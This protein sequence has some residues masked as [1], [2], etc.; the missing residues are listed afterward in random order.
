[1]RRMSLLLILLMAGT[2]LA[3]WLVARPA[4]A[5]NHPTLEHE[6]VV[7]RA[8]FDDP[9][10]VAVVARTQEPWEVDYHKNFMVLEVD[11]AEYQELERLG[12]RLEV[13]AEL[14]AEINKIRLPLPDQVSGIPG[15]PCY[16][17]V[18]E[19]FATAVAL[20]ANYPTLAEWI[21]VGDS[22]EK[23]AG[24]GGY[25]M[26]VLILTNEAIQA[27][28]PKL[29]VTSAIHAREYTTAELMTRFAE[30]LIYAY[31][32]DADA[33]WLLDHHEV[34]LMLHTNPDG[35]KQAETGLSWRKNTNQNYCGP[36]SSSRGADLNRNFQFQWGCCGGSSGNECSETF[37][38][39]SPAS[40][41]EVQAVQNY[42]FANYPDLRDP[43]LNAAAPVTTTGIYLDIHSYSE[44]VLWSWGFTATPTANGTALQTL[45]RKMA[46]F[47]GYFPEQAIGLYPTDGTTDDF[48]YGELGLPS[49]TFELGTA[50]FQGCGFFEND[51][52]PGNMPALIYA[53]KAA[54]EPYLAPAGPEP[55]D[56]EVSEIIV[57]SGTPVTLTAV[58][59]DTR[60]NNQNGTEPTQNI[61]AGEYYLD[62]PP[63]I[64]E[65]TPVALPLT[66]VDG[67]FN[68]P[69]E[70]AY[71]V[72]DTSVLADGRH[73]IYVRGQDATGQ[74]G[75]V[76]AA[77]LFIVDP[78]IA[79]V[80][81]GEVSAA[82]TGLPLAATITANTIFQTQ[83]DPLTGIYQMQVI[84]DTYAITAVPD[85]PNYASATVSG[86][87][88]QNSQTVVQD[89]QLYP[90]CDVFFDDV[91]AGNIGWTFDPPWAI[92]TEASHSPTHSWTDSPGGNY[93]NNRNIAITSPIIDLTDYTNIRLNYWQI[94]D[95][96]ADYDFCHVEVS[97]DGGTNW[98]EIGSFDGPHTQWEEITLDASLL[99][100]QAN[101]RI[102]FRFTSD[103]S[104]VDD[105]WHVDDIRLRG[106]GPACVDYVAPNASFTTS[107]P[108]ALGEAT[109]FN[110]ESTGS[111][112]T[113]AWDF[114]DGN[115]STLVN[116]A[117]T[118][119]AVGSY[120]VT[121]TA[122]NNL[123]SD[124]ATAV[125]EIW[126]APQA[127]FIAPSLLPLG[128]TAVFTNTSTGDNL[129]H[130]WDFGDGNTSTETNPSH[131]YAAEGD[132]TVTLT[133]QNEV[134]SDVATAVVS[135]LAMP[136]AAF[137]ATN[138]TELGSA[139][140]FTN[141]STG[142]ALSFWWDF[143]DTTTS[144]ESSPSHTYATTGTFTVTLTVSN[145]VGV[146]VATAVVE[147]IAPV[148]TPGYTLFL[149]IIVAS[150]PE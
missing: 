2:G 143:G 108:D 82:D 138:P 69:V 70:A 1:M 79:P 127:S 60:Y 148:V 22:W 5:A 99:D 140:I 6:I 117:H 20:A 44:L 113:F 121:L 35:R 97:A 11:A 25:D 78:A 110:N 120:T 125:V 74:W 66:A 17:T 14:T 96:E 50:F 55:L 107:S 142:G 39:P 77:F 94:C 54:R 40:E 76:S 49:Y 123:G 3:F 93:T 145:A 37:R 135:I 61:A 23:T 59:N 38:G 83:T 115:S 95:T 106:A 80:L 86:I 141:T 52:I 73:L 132:Y 7:V 92:T 105:G 87:V 18:E 68:S 71:A 45:G 33:T 19:T 4:P 139:T 67:N 36:T 131:L 126:N 114:G 30:Y 91:E 101:A 15:Y 48:G 65:T 21:D 136:Q 103:V 90:Y 72:I 32:T 144:T 134:G 150:L 100:N 13:D 130:L 10:I 89:F 63:W 31:N 118:Y 146:D 46:Y 41:P 104:L 8:Y 98:Y 122:T 62:T 57:E 47:N 26:Q 128:E 12:L 51:I 85:D 88:A 119:A 42:I 111:E 53:A 75:V 84:S 24:L 56:V 149:P 133:A 34:H 16:R 9:A 112:L 81:A 116:P 109:Q 102:R 28:K 147:V 137:T 64:T 129:T 124:V 29:F 27:D 58:L 43:D